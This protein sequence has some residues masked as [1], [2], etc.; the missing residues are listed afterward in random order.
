MFSE[1][2]QGQAQ[3]SERIL[4]QSGRLQLVEATLPGERG[5]VVDRAYSVRQPGY[6][7]FYQGPNLQEAVAA[8]D[9]A[10]AGAA[11]DQ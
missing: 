6:E 10:V 3:M 9:R 4:R 2:K 5:Q 8:F 1:E 11:N 7:N